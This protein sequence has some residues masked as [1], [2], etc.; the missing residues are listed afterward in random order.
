MINSTN[1]MSKFH[2]SIY[3]SNQERNYS[4]Y[5]IIGKL[6]MKK[7]FLRGKF[8]EPIKEKIKYKLDA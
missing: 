2:Y 1:A 8:I 3:H 7:Y 5:K 4:E 6:L